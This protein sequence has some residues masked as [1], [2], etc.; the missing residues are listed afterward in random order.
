MQVIIMMLFVGVAVQPACL[1]QFGAA[2][3]LLQRE[4]VSTL[5]S[6]SFIHLQHLSHSAESVGC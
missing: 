6:I 3:R 5:S 2:A 4:S 1:C